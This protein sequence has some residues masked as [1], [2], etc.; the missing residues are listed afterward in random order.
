MLISP[1]FPLKS[2]KVDEILSTI[3]EKNERVPVNRNSETRDFL[4]RFF[5]EI[6]EMLQNLHKDFLRFYMIIR[7][8]GEITMKIRNLNNFGKNEH[9]SVRPTRR[10]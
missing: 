7:K 8:V 2:E 6:V 5:P 4:I 3:F 10:N 1:T 9:E